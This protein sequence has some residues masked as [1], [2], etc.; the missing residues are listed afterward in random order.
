[1]PSFYSKYLGPKLS[2]RVNEALNK[3]HDEQVAL[4]EELAIARS[5]ACEALR[6]ASP[7]FDEK[8]GTKLSLETK[9]LMAQTLNQAMNAVKELVLAA[10][11]IE[12]EQS[13]KVSVKVINL[14]VMQIVMAINDVCGVDN[15]ELAE[16]IARRIDEKVRLPI[17]ER[18]NPS[19]EIKVE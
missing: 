13:D 11:K 3:P 7:L 18:L 1:L 17:N 6:L 19:I 15:M 5:T 10:S 2:E 9:A 16:A 14:I 8:I 12:K 4:Y